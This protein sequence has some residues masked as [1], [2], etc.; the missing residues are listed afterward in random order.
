MLGGM[1]TDTEDSG[2]RILFGQNWQ[3]CA[4]VGGL[5]QGTGVHTN[6]NANKQDSYGLSHRQSRTD[7]P[8]AAKPQAIYN[9]CALNAEEEQGRVTHRPCA[10]QGIG[11]QLFAF[12]LDSLVLICEEAASHIRQVVHHWKDSGSADALCAL[13]YQESVMKHQG[14]E[15]SDTTSEQRRANAKGARK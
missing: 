2:G 5:E 1:V 7:L 12:N 9:R 3:V 14:A 13:T 11:L 4:W 6:K 8:S 10:L 15:A